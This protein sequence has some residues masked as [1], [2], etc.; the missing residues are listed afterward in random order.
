[1]FQLGGEPLEANQIL[2]VFLDGP[3]QIRTKQ[4]SVD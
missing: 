1:L 2:G 4:C 3:R